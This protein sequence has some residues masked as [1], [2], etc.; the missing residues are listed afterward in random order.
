MNRMP[1]EKYRM[2]E[3]IDLPDRQWPSRVVDKAPIWCSVDLRDGNQALIEPMGPD[4]KRRMFKLL[5]DMGFKEIEIGFPSASQTDFDFTR[6]LIEQNMIPEDVTV[7]VLTQARPQLIERTFESLKGV[8]RAIVHVY[9]STSTIQRRV[10]FQQDRAGVKQIALDGAK[11]VREY[12]E[13]NPGTDWRFEYSPESY[14]QTELDYALEVCESVMD[15]WEPTPQKPCILNLPATVEVAP[16][17]VYADSIEWMHRHFTRRDSLILSVHPHNDRGSG[18]VAAEFAQM[19]GADRVEG[20]LFGNGERTGNVDIVT[21]GVNMVA[22]G[23]D[24]M[25]DFSNIPE[26]RKVVEYCNQLPVHPRH[27]YGGDLVFTA[28]SGSHQDAIKKGLT[29]MENSN[30]GIWDVPYLP[31]DP[32]DVGA[33]YE[34]VIRVN[35]QSGK[36]GVAYILESDFGV[37]MPRNLQIEFSTVIQKIAD[38]SGKEL[39]SKM[40]WESFCQTYLDNETPYSF[41]DHTTKAE[42]HASEIRSITAK[43]KKNGKDISLKGRG[44]GPIDA[45]VNALVAD[46]G[47]EISVMDYTEH[48]MG[49]GANAKAIAYVEARTASGKRIY[50]VGSHP[51]IVTASLKAV[52]CAMNRAIA[53]A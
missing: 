32:A 15:I 7:Q 12:A 46:S 14:T 41:V 53:M 52:T 17:N 47:V 11:M 30:T 16:P 45:Y 27:P 42:T 10:V 51:N 49:Q 26:M 18:V 2:F 25:L 28:F 33:S 44:N 29:A 3:R 22:S 21:L 5:V 48:A 6:E 24:P 37:R 19:A 35:S 39:V 43:V 8:H 1:V 40:I 9:N 50:G 38:E 20:T 13:K 36:G 31:I 23:V 4:R 34:A